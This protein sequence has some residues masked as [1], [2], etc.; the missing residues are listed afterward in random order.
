MRALPLALILAT[1]PAIGPSS[2]VS[3]SEAPTIRY[4]AAAEFLVIELYPGGPGSAEGDAAFTRIYGDGRVHVHRPSFYRESGDFEAWLRLRDLDSLLRDFAADGIL[5][6]DLRAVKE[7]RLVAEREQAEKEGSVPGI[8]DAATVTLTI[9]LDQYAPAGATDPTDDYW[10]T[11]SWYALDEDAEWYP[12]IEPL[13]RLQRAVSRL[14]D[15]TGHAMAAARS[16][17]TIVALPAPR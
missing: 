10:K 8:A 16:G 11:I 5:H 4:P 14:E 6:F 7:R 12:E 17:D 2:A 15:L 13:V 9:R 1:S 3:A